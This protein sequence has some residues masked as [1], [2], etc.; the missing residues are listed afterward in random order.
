MAISSFTKHFAVITGLVEFLF[1]TGYFFGWANLEKIFIAEGFF[2]CQLDSDET[3]N[4]K[5][6]LLKIFKNCS[7]FFAVPALFAGLI[8]DRFGTAVS[9]LIGTFTFALGLVLIAFSTPE[10]PLGL[11]IGVPTTAIGSAFLL[12]SNFQLPNIYESGRTAALNLFN[13]ALDSSALT[14]LILLTVYKMLGMKLTF[15]IYGITCVFQLAR[16]I[17]QLPH[18]NIPFPVPANWK[19][20]TPFRRAK[21]LRNN[22]DVFHDLENEKMV[23]SE[24]SSEESSLDKKGHD[25]DVTFKACATRRIYISANLFFV[26]NCF[27]VYWYLASV[28]GS[29]TE[30]IRRSDENVTS[31]EALELTDQMTTVFGVIQSLAI[32]LAPIN[33]IIIDQVLSKTSNKYLAIL[34]SATCCNVLGVTF[35]FLEVANSVELQYVTMVVSALHRAFTFSCHTA[36]IGILFPHHHFGKLF[37]VSQAFSAIA[38]FM[39]DYAFRL[40]HV[41]GFYQVNVWTAF[42]Q[43]AMMYH[44]IVCYLEYRLSLIHI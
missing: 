33:G 10:E 37:G 7:L 18:D 43:V 15:L 9:R 36:L 26:V 27:R 3:C 21:Q 35:S 41:V 31:E 19:W 44:P 5:Y 1:C 40:E 39:V 29:I 17:F 22:Q 30:T 4:Q 6:E 32:F 38:S 14:A 2:E 8:F 24:T 42:T 25:D 11:Q 34:I 28:G 16:T 23:S 12:T 13:G 20:V